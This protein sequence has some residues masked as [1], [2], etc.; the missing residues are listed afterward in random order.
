MKTYQPD[1][2]DQST[3]PSLRLLGITSDGA[4]VFERHWPYHDVNPLFL[5]QAIT[6][7]RV[8]GSPFAVLVVELDEPV[9]M[10]ECVETA[11]NDFIA[12]AVRLNRREGHTRFVLNRFPEPSSKM[13]L[14]LKRLGPAKNDYVLVTAYVGE[15]HQPEPFDPAATERSWD[16]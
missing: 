1:V 5:V 10:T 8:D 14:I 15:R 6:R 11:P 7:A 13:T 9:G 3:C 4:K 12:Y 2:A 16:F